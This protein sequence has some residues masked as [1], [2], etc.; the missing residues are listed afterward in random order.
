FSPAEALRKVQELGSQLSSTARSMADDLA[1]SSAGG[2]VEP[3]VRLGARIADLSTLWVGPVR[4]M[5]QQQQELVDT[6]ESWAKQQHELADRFTKLAENQRKLT[7]RVLKAIT[8]QIDQAEQ[9]RAKA[10]S[11]SSRSKKPS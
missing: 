10:R 7:D 9:V 11:V 1:G 4:A 8:P 6:M 5:L 3:F 2:M